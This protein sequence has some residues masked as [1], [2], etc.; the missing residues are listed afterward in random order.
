[1]GF[2]RTFGTNEV[3]I[4]THPG[5]FGSVGTAIFA[6]NKTPR[7]GR[8]SVRGQHGEAELADRL[9]IMLVFDNDLGLGSAQNFLRPQRGV[10]AAVGDK[11]N[12]FCIWRPTWRNVVEVSIRKREGVTA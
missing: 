2:E 10:P 3:V 8:A 1:M 12:A 7:C 6:G 5:I 11:C 4:G 9:E